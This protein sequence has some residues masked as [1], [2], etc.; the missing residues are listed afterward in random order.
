MLPGR[1]SS[2]M[3][4][5]SKIGFV[6]LL[7]FFIVPQA[8]AALLPVQLEENFVVSSTTATHTVLFWVGTGD[9]VTVINSMNSSIWTNGSGV[10]AQMK[11]Q[12][13]DTMATTAPATSVGCSNSAAVESDVVNIAAGGP[14]VAPVYTFNFHDSTPL[15]NGQWYLVI[16]SLIDV[17]SADWEVR[18]K[19]SFVLDDQCTFAGNASR[20]VGSPLWLYNAS[21]VFND[22]QTIATSSSLFSGQDATTTLQALSRQCSQTGNIFAEGI[23][24]AFSF[25]FVP[26][27]TSLNQFSNLAVLAET[28]IPFSYVLSIENAFNNIVLNAT[29]SLPI[30]DIPL[31]RYASS[32]VTGV[33][34]D[35]VISTST[36][37]TY[38]TDN[39]RIPLQLLLTAAIW[40]AVGWLV[41]HEAMRAFHTT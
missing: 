13:F 37:S 20:C 35:I 25:L 15:Q 7:A 33:I 9:G 29:S 2:S 23:C 6:I 31:S 8:H 38:F 10:T 14:D 30:I 28:R 1:N 5:A 21:V 22:P 4:I 41:F 11:Y 16:I 18:G 27:Q 3:K 26:S 12:C 40:L 19:G 34:P 32:T 39:I 24:I 36:I 17:G